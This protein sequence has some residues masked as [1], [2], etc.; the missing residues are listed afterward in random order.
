MHPLTDAPEGPVPG[1]NIGYKSSVVQSHPKLFTAGLWE[2]FIHQELAKSG[3]KFRV[4]PSLE[5]LHCKAFTAADFQ[6]Q[7]FHFARS[8]G[9]MRATTVPPLKLWMFRLLSPGLPVL[10]LWRLFRKVILEK[11]RK[12]KEFLLSLPWIF[13]F[14]LCWCAGE[15]SGYWF[16]DRGSTEIVK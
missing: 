13:W 7:S 3:V 5:V 12:Q 1:N 8:F 11:K 15:I 2:F 10:V 9:A 6:N 14:Q 4:D 16:G